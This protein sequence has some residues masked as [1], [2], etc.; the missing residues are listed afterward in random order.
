MYARLRNT[1]LALI[2]APLEP[3]APPPGSRE[4]LRVFRAAPCFVA[5]RM[6][7]HGIGAS[8]VLAFEA[9]LLIAALASENPAVILAV[10]LLVVVPTLVTIFLTYFFVRLDYEMRYYI[11][12]DHALRIREGVFRIREI[13]VTYANVQHMQITQGPLAR[14]FEISDLRVRTAS[15]APAQDKDGWGTGHEAVFRGVNRPQE[16]RD[17]LDRLIRRHRGAGLGDPEE[18]AGPPT[19]ARPAGMLSPLAIQRL[20]EI[21]DEIRALRSSMAGGA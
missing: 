21:R 20:R 9:G 17:E 3:P 4:H 8:V 5:Y 19:D 2:K 6:V 10:L 14:L 12:A 13:T 7:S 16:L 1:L 11:L 15:G 18:H